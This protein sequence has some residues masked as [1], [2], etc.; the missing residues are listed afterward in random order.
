MLNI[1]FFALHVLE[2]E[3]LMFVFVHYWPCN[4]RQ[5]LGSNKSLCMLAFD[6]LIRH[7]MQLP[8]CV[9]EPLNVLPL[10]TVKSPCG[11]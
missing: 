3:L 11:Q 6:V 8:C 1:F 7:D 4:R 9:R 2:M 5:L 10:E